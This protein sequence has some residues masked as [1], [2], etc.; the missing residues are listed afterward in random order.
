MIRIS[1]PLRQ[2][3]QLQQVFRSTTDRQ[4]SDRSQ[5]VLLAQRGRPHQDIARDLA[6]TP[7]TVQR[8]LNA[9]LECGLDGLRPKKARASKVD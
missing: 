4:L 2:R 9:Y 1:L 5:I 6:I 8:W 7:R 3:A